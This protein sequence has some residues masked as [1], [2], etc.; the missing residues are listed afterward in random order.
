MLH[1]IRQLLTRLRGIALAAAAA[2]AIAEALVDVCT[3]R[4]ESLAVALRIG[5]TDVANAYV[6]AFPK[7]FA[8][9]ISF[10]TVVFF[11]FAFVDCLLALVA[12]KTRFAVARV[13][14]FVSVNTPAAI[15]AR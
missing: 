6:L 4:F 2:A 13:V 9:A 14:A 3:C 10:I 1:K 12:A 5:K 7:V 8:H 15:L 11:C